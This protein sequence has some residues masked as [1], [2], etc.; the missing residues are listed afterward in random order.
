MPVLLANLEYRPPIPMILL[1]S[2]KRP[3]QYGQANIFP[4]YNSLFLRFD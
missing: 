2:E 4:L 1:Q 3:D